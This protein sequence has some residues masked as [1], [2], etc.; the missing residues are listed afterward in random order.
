MKAN[1]LALAYNDLQNDGF[2]QSMF[3]GRKKNSLSANMGES[4]KPDDEGE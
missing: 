1:P 2:R 3:N 4:I